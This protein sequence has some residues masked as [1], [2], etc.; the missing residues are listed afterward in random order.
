MTNP[1]PVQKVDLIGLGR[2]GSALAEALL[3]RKHPIIVCNRSP[4]KSRALGTN[5]AE[6]GKITRRESS[7]TA[8][9]LRGITETG[10]PR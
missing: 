6:A 5:G 8:A 9:R 4:D 10:W 7:L 1:T 3:P 2:M